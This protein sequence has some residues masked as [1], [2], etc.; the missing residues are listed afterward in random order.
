MVN[1]PKEVCAIE[2]RVHDFGVA[3]LVLVAV[4]NTWHVLQALFVCQRELPFIGMEIEGAE[5]KITVT[6]IRVAIA[7]TVCWSSA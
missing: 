3:I 4:H 6:G 7:L 5:R 1:V 2:Q